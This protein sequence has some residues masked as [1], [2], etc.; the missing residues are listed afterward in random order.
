MPVVY[1]QEGWWFS[2]DEVDDSDAEKYHWFQ[3]GN[4]EKTFYYTDGQPA[5][6]FMYLALKNNR[7]ICCLSPRTNLRLE[8][9]SE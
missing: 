6:P 1:Q 5:Q 7:K 4:G 3:R 8:L 9:G 2:G